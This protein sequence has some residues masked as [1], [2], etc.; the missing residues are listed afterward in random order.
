MPANKK[1]ARIIFSLVLLGLITLAWSE[2]VPS[3]TRDDLGHYINAESAFIDI[4]GQSVHYR[5]EGNPD[6]PALMLIH[7][8][9]SSL[10]TWD[11]WVAALG[12]HFDLVRMD[13][14]AFGLTGARK[15]RD[16]SLPAYVAFIDAFADAL[17]IES[18]A[19]AGNSHGG[20]VSWR[21]AAAHPER[22]TA[23]VLLDPSGAIDPDRERPLAFKLA[24]LPLVS[25]LI[26]Y[27]GHRS[28]Y[29]KSVQQV[30]GDDS[31]IT[32]ALVDR[33]YQLALFEGNRQ[34]F[35]DRA[36]NPAP[37][38]TELLATID[39]PTLILWGEEDTW[40]PISDANRF[41]ELLPQ[42]TLITYPG[43][44]HV[45]MEEIPAQSAADARAFLDTVLAR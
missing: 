15:D 37:Q 8:T 21:Y 41:V 3:L 20:H 45:P 5:R 42:S 36:Q 31:L 26:P 13:L 22:V 7:G 39:I 19:L 25:R 34:A 33:Y 32:D 43:V 30:Y 27:L 38:R 2:Y 44:G 10:H 17:D 11:G 24:N 4:D 6:G 1:R 40:I 28:I 23:L 35:V 29:E 16:Y 12:D 18:M 14:P 9:S